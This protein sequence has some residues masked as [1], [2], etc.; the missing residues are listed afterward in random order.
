MI[1]EPVSRRYARAL[2]AA[3][4]AGDLLDVVEADLRS[5]EALRKAHPELG[6]ML[7]APLLD[8]PRKRALIA[9]VLTGRVHPLVVELLYLLL[10]KKRLALFEEI[11]EVFHLLLDEHRGIVTAEVTTATPLS[12]STVARLV[13]RLEQDTGKSVVLEKHVRPSILG[14][15][16]VRFGDR[17]MD[18]SIRR[19]LDEIRERLLEVPVYD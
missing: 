13:A 10:E 12:E 19:A 2:F 16:M 9:K 7:L 11:F 18:R 3:A 5:I 8:E 1:R 17:I 4:E 15:I 14:G 6:Y